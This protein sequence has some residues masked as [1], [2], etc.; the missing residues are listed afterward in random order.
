MTTQPAAQENDWVDA[1]HSGASD[2]SWHSHTGETPPQHAHGVT[3]PL[4][5]FLIGIVCTI[6]VLATMAVIAQYF[7]MGSQLEIAAKQEVNL[8]ADFA[9]LQE[10]WDAALTGYGWVD[11][12]NGVVRVPI[13]TAIDAVVTEYSQQ[14]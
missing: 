1:D 11:A 4:N 13:Q 5:I 12:A 6:L 9:D 8:G 7:V 10:S 2:D 14:R 3:S